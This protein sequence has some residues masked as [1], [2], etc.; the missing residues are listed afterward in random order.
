MHKLKSHDSLTLGY[1]QI[2]KNLVFEGGKMDRK[3]LAFFVCTQKHMGLPISHWTGP[4]YM[5]R[6]FKHFCAGK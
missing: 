2:D 5:V 3:D 4:P 1:M 6:E